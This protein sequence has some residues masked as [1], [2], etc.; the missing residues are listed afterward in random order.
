MLLDMLQHTGH[1][2]Q[3]RTTQPQISVMPLLRKPTLSYPVIHIWIL[4]HLFGNLLNDYLTISTDHGE[5]KGYRQPLKLYTFKISLSIEQES[6][7]AR[8]SSGWT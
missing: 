4:I 5:L 7:V 3:Q 8:Q 1:F 2:P 6:L